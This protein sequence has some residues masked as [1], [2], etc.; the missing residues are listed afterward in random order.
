[1]PHNTQTLTHTYVRRARFFPF[2]AAP[3]NLTSDS[4][5][6]MTI[7]TG[8]PYVGT[9]V[10]PVHNANMWKLV[11]L[12]SNIGG[13]VLLLL[14]I[15]GFSRVS[16][17]PPLVT[18]LI[19]WFTADAILIPW[20]L[21]QIRRRLVLDFDTGTLV[22]GGV[23]Y[24]AAALYALVHTSRHYMGAAQLLTFMY[25]NGHIKVQV[26]GFTPS[27][28]TQ[29]RNAALLAFIWQCLPIPAQHSEYIGTELALVKHLI[30]KQ[31]ATVLLRG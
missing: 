4:L 1:M 25:T 27:A 14:L 10:V 7:Q 26:D 30:G 8:Q 9:H 13:A 16:L 29:G 21:V 20:T 18:G 15:A 11:I 31:E 23:S 3:P 12:A 24:P 19:I 2:S 17:V 22:C 6:I 28:Q 5:Q